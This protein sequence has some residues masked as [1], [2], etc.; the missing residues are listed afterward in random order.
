M[1]SRWRA[2]S[3]VRGRLSNDGKPVDGVSVG[4]VQCDRSSETFLGT[5]A[6]GTK[7][8][9]TFEFSYVPPEDDF[10]IYTTMDSTMG[11]A[12]PLR[13]VTI[14]K[15]ESLM[16]LGDLELREAHMLSGRNV[17]TDGKPV[18]GPIQLLLSR[19]G[20][21]DSQKTM[22]GSDGAFHFENVPGQE[23][24]TF[25]ARIPGYEL[26]DRNRMQQVQEWSVA[27][28]VEGPRD[29]IEILYEPATVK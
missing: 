24:V 23:P 1:S 15:S 22:L 5:Y 3:L 27:M 7:K 11:G 18:P 14:G 19:E 2:A 16:D 28:F 26:S 9:G 29:D 20:A 4:L 6:I 17:L 8:D 21:W 10:Y 12:L 13:R 25:I